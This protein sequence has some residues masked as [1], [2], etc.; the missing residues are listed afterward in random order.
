MGL[1]LPRLSERPYRGLPSGNP[2]EI[3]ASTVCDRGALV[4]FGF[5]ARQTLGGA[6][7][8][9]RKQRHPH[10][11]PEATQMPAEQPKGFSGNCAGHRTRCH[12][13]SPGWKG[14]HRGF[15]SWRERGECRLIL[16][17]PRRL[18]APASP[19]SRGGQHPHEFRKS[20]KMRST[21]RCRPGRVFRRLMIH[22][23]DPVVA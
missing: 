14:G 11:D 10:A 7:L 9:Q 2:S 1:V 23:K 5:P 15:A 13:A 20:H 22:G 3:P 6:P 16:V 21:A 4:S 12:R 19:H 18:D 8:L 17:P